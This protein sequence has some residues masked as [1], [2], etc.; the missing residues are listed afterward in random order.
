MR[1][2]T[3]SKAEFCHEKNF[4]TFIVPPPPGFFPTFRCL[5]SNLRTLHILQK[6]VYLFDETLN[7]PNLPSWAVEMPLFF[8]SVAHNSKLFLVCFPASS[9][10]NE[11]GLP[12][13][14]HAGRGIVLSRSNK[15]FLILTS[16]L[17]PLATS[18]ILF[19]L[20]TLRSFHRQI[21]ICLGYV[22]FFPNQFNSD[23]Y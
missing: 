1:V 17:S 16:F 18:L 14:I 19:L 8:T 20:N 12:L 3:A 6:A 7:I 15:L 11:A 5:L 23:N 22:I 9:V 13:N 10:T 21:R 4:N 2:T